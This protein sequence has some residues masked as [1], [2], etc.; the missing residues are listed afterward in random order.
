MRS[1]NESYKNQISQLEKEVETKERLSRV[2]VVEVKRLQQTCKDLMEGN[3]K[4]LQASDMYNN[5]NGPIE[6]R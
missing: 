4:L 2:Q 3:K 5:A 6:V 1:E